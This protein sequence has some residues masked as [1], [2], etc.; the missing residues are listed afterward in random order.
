MKEIFFFFIFLNIALAGYINAWD[1]DFSYPN[2]GYA[3]LFNFYFS[4]ENDLP[5]GNFIEMRFPFSLGSSPAPLLSLTEML[6]GQQY[7]TEKSAIIS[8]EIKTYFWNISTTLSSNK[9]YKISISIVDT[10]AFGDQKEGFSTPIH[11]QTVSSTLTDRYV[12]DENKNFGTIFLNPIPKKN[13]TLYV[14]YP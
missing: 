8:V 3:K 13:L 5:Q 14:T 6:S 12:I 10:N 1:M 7:E 2:I 9:W 4:L 11:F